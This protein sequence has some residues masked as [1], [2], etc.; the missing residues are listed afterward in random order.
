[1]FCSFLVMAAIE[2]SLLIDKPGHECLPEP[3]RIQLAVPTPPAEKAEAESSEPRF[4]FP[5]A[6]SYGSP[7]LCAVRGAGG[8]LDFAMEI[9]KDM[10]RPLYI[11]FVREQAVLTLEDRNRT[12]KND[13]DACAL[14]TLPPNHGSRDRNEQPGDEGHSAADGKVVFEAISAGMH[15]QPCGLVPTI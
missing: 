15:H 8:T 1:M 5:E 7:I 10:N 14:F 13:Q 3:K 9:A 6:T 2:I 12:W 11:M 4:E